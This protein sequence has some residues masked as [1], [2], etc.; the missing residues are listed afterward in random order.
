MEY[1]TDILGDEE[2]PNFM[3]GVS[4]IH[5][6]KCGDVELVIDMG[7]TRVVSDPG[8]LGK[9]KLAHFTLLRLLG[10]GGFGSVWLAVDDNLGRQVALKIPISKDGESN[11]L[12]HE[13][14]TAA[15]LKH[16]NIVSIYEVGIEEGRIFI[17]SEFI[18]GMTLRDFLSS[19]KPTIQRTVELLIPIANALQHANDHGVVHRDIKPANIILNHAGQPFVNDFGLATT[20]NGQ[21]HKAEAVIYRWEDEPFVDQC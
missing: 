11:S 9:E 2:T 18:D 15:R 5:C 21:Q 20:L 4:S 3:D 16:P 17:A 14:K 7:E 12:L 19:G 6:P 1:E 10:R 8:S 13:A